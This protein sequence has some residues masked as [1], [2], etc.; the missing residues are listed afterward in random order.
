MQKGGVS[1]IKRYDNNRALNFF[2]K[3][4]TCNILT[5]QSR[6]GIIFKLT[7]NEYKKVKILC[8]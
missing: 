8:L 7:L 4:Y 1:I 3:N 2:L 5:Y 6:G